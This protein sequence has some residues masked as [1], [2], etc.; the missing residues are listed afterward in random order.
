[1]TFHTPR[2]LLRPFGTADLECVFTGLSH[3][4]VIRHYGISFTTL[5]ATQEQMDRYA[6]IERD[7]SGLWRAICALEDGTFI[8]AIGLNNVVRDQRKGEVGFW[9]MPEHR[10]CG[11]I[12]EA[13]PV[14]LEHGFTARGLH[15]IEAEVET[16]NHASA[17][18]LR[19]YGF[20]HEGTL[21]DRERKDERWISLDVFAML[22]HHVDHATDR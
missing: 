19:K 9:L 18:V 6:A 17:K 20:V 2:L 5:E 4:D 12:G 22:E 3:P 13:L 21:R 7:G 10:S 15:R 8:G 14:I 1:M 11:Y 16:E